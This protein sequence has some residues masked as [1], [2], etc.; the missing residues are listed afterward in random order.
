MDGEI[1]KILNDINNRIFL[2]G[3][4]REFVWKPGQIESLF[5]SLIRE[6][7]VGIVTIWKTKGGKISEYT[8]YKFLN[9]HV[10][11]DYQL[12]EKIK[13]DYSRYNDEASDKNPEFLIIDGQ[14]RL[15]SLYIGIYGEVA[16][17]VG[18]QGRKSSKAKNWA[19]KVLCVDLFGHPD[20]A[21][22]DKIA[23]DYQFQFRPTGQL[24]KENKIGYE[25][26]GEAHVLWIPIK[27]FWNF[28]DNNNSMG[29]AI[30]AKEA[31]ERINK[32]IRNAPIP[33]DTIESI[34]LNDV[35]KEVGRDVRNKILTAELETKNIKKDRSEIP[36]IFQRLNREGEQ[37]QPYQLLLSQMMSYWPYLDDNPINPRKEIADWVEKFKDDFGEYEQ[38]ID[39][40]LF[41]R[42]SV[43]LLNT[44]LLL[45]KLDNISEDDLDV[46]H[47]K[48][49]YTEPTKNISG[50]DWFVRSLRKSFKT[51][52]KAGIRPKLL[53]SM[54]VFLLLAV[55]YYENPDATI[56]ENKNE[57]FSFISKAKLLS[58]SGYR[59]LG[60]GKC[61]S[62]RR[63]LLKN[64][65]DNQCSIFPGDELL[66]NEGMTVSK[67]DVESAVKDTRY[68]GNENSSSFTDSKAISILGLLYEESID[69]QDISDYEVDHIY[70]KK[71]REQIV[72]ATGKEI[73]LDRVGNLQLLLQSENRKKGSKLPNEW[74]KS[75]PQR[76]KK[77]IKETSKYPD[78][79]LDAE[80]A[81]E[82]INEREE[83]IF[84]YLVDNYV[85]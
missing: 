79:D 74:I 40:E 42:Y 65:S 68:A 2:P 56:E 78:I 29:Y 85:E 32:K 5:D 23:G 53:S 49:T 9:S 52:I 36:E 67:N 58:Q 19:E 47:R 83:K 34:G 14:Q 3:L 10:A 30:E 60:Y 31:N 20:Y 82:F 62:Y 54:P 18:G 28:S 38:E 55:F 37:P 64:H 45:S 25:Q 24:G 43:F 1:E 21:S 11:S 48:W 59:A 17:Y 84:K 57:I 63:Y 81:N 71:K 51:I 72:E 22:K 15:N 8:T 66:N 44:D 41:V 70:P 50:Y 46:L 26:R 61:R 7:P 27:K 76:L 13:D 73:D 33:S 12:P 80:N 6:Y 69:K 75:Y 16:E 35:A 4:Q 39:R 77:E